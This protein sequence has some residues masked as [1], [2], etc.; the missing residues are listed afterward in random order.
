MFNPLNVVSMLLFLLL[1]KC[2]FGMVYVRGKGASFPNEVY[3]EWRPAY[4]LHRRTY[5]DLEMTY[6]AIGSGN[7][8]AAIMENIDIE[9]AGTDSLL[10]NDTTTT[11][12]DLI[13]FPIMAG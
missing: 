5:V 7:G 10:S 1:Y 8:K 12:P 2:V 3:K 4:H 6:S 9:Y 11:H 13:L